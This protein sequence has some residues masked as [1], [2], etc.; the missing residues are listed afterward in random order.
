MENNILEVK[1]LSIAFQNEKIINNISFVVKKNDFL[2]IIGPNGSGKTVLL[3]IL[4]G[5]IKKY[6]GKVSW[7]KNIKIGYLP[8]GLTRLALEKLPL[9]VEDFL[10][11]K[12]LSRDKI[13]EVL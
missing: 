3:R 13:V 12:K 7:K 10:R 5:L 8:Q 2:T 9:T 1:K 6:Q 11:L 4:L